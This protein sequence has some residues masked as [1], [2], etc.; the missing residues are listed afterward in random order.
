MGKQRE[1]RLRRREDFSAVYREGH[2]E[3][4]RLL[5]VRA[6]PNGRSVSRVGFVAGRAFAGAVERNRAKRRLRAAASALALRPGLDIVVGARGGVLTAPYRRLTESLRR[7]LTR[8]G[9]LEE[10]AS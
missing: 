5:V 6:R 1:G 8:C 7:L 4:D 2:V 10:A 9:A 3:Q